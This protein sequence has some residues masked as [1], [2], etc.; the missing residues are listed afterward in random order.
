MSKVERT[1]NDSRLEV[2]WNRGDTSLIRRMKQKGG[3]V[4]RDR[5][6]YI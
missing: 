1:T 5:N 4:E 2:E 3:I 6:I